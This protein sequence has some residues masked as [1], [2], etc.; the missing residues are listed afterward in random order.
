MGSP[1]IEHKDTVNRSMTKAPE[2]VNGERLHQM[3]LELLDKRLE[4]T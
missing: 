3:I 2:K 4:K 1:G